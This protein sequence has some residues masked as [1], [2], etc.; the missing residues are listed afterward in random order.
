MRSCIGL[1]I[2]LVGCTSPE[3]AKL[4]SATFTPHM[5][6]QVSSIACG[7]DIAFYGS[8]TTDLRYDFVYDGA[9]HITAANGTWLDYGATESTAYTWNG[10]NLTHMLW[11]TSWD[12]S[13]VEI[14]ASYDAAN[15]LVDYTWAAATPDYQDAWT[16]SFSNFAGPYEPLREVISQSGQPVV[17][18]DLVYDDD[19]LVQAI[20]DSGPS[21][22]WSYDDVARTITV[23]TGNGAFVGVMTYAA[24]YRPLSSS[25][26]GTDPSM[27]DGDEVYAWNGPRL[28][29]IT[30]RSGTEDAPHQLDLVEV[31]TMRYSC[32]M[33]RAG[34]RT[35]RFKS[36]PTRSRFGF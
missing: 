20:P 25:W 16:Y 33:A 9:E 5:E 14:T 7:E 11:T 27:I 36:P 32:A 12:S 35:K 26:T 21:T 31:E 24:D 1:T 8:P 19:R 30:Y 23:D 4:P 29:T 10:D 6:A 15:N 34:A 13:Q 28:D 17:S 3:E 2:C 22:T 18:Y